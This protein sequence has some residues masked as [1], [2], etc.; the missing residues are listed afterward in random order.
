MVIQRLKLVEPRADVVKETVITK[1]DLDQKTPIFE[2]SQKGIFEKEVDKAVLDERVDFAVH[3]LK[4]IPVF[5]SDTELTIA[6]VL[7]RGPLGDVLVSRDN[8]KLNELKSG[9]V[10]GT[11]SLLRVAQLKRV[12]PDLEASPIRGNVETR[13][14]KVSDALY[15]G[16]ILAEAGVA[17]LELFDSISES[18]SLND[19]L[20]A[21]GQGIIA[22]VARRD[23]TGILELLSRVN[24]SATDAEAEAERE[25]VRVLESGCRL[26]LGAYARADGN[27]ILLTACVLSSDGRERIQATGTSSLSDASKLGTSIGSELLTKGADKIEDT[28]HGRWPS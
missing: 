25:L 14:R 20:P 26:P 6:C 8:R 22:V 19:F 1:G 28:W 9:S 12:R 5:E 17:R 4:D 11:S 24:H 13:I 21:P 18:L 10:I 27:D 16:A 3:S 15:D 2:I 7:E 23:N